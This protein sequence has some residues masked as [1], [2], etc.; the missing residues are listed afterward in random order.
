[1]NEKVN[2][3][4]NS[5]DESLESPRPALKRFSSGQRVIV[6]AAEHELH[7][8]KGTVMRLRS[9]DDAA[10][11]Q[12]DERPIQAATLFPFQD[13]EGDPR[14]NHAMLWPDECAPAN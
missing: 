9:S 6:T 8:I 5:R 4:Q 14:Q 10:W 3:D 11:V 2:E 13:A 1:V 12:M 7:G